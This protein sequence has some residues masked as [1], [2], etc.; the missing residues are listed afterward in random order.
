MRM[1]PTSSRLQSN[2]N[3]KQAMIKFMRPTPR[4]LKRDQFHTYNLHTTPADATTPTYKL[5][6]P[7]FEEGTPQKWSKFW[8]RLQAVLKGQHITQ[9]PPSYAVTKTLLKGN[10]LTVLKQAEITHRNQAVTNFELCLED[11]AKRV[12]PEKSGQIQKRYMRR[13]ICYSRGTTV[14]EW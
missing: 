8:C 13:N 14:K 11:M 5:S 7:F 1:A 6:I 2:P 3:V 12:F 9:G 10:M 4:Q